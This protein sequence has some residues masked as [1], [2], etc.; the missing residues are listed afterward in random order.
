MREDEDA[1]SEG[2]GIPNANLNRRG[3][4]K[5]ATAGVFATGATANMTTV[6]ADAEYRFTAQ[7]T[8]GPV[9]PGE[10]F[11]IFPALTNIGD[12]SGEAAIYFQ[13]ATNASHN[14]DYYGTDFELVNHVDDGGQ[15]EYEGWSWALTE[16]EQALE[17]N[18][19]LEVDED[20]SSGEYTFALEATNTVQTEVIDTKTVTVTVEEPKRPEL[21]LTAK[22][23]S[24]PVSVGDSA[25]V[26]FE[27][28]NTGTEMAK[29]V[30]IQLQ[31]EGIAYD[32]EIDETASDPAG[33]AWNV[34]DRNW[35][36]DELPPNETEAP[37]VTFS[38]P[39]DVAPGTYTVTAEAKSDD[40]E[41]DRKTA[42]IV[43]KEP[44]RPE[45]EV[46]A[47]GPA[48]SVTAGQE[49]TVEVTLTNHGPGTASAVTTQLFALFSE[50]A[51][52]TIGDVSPSMGEWVQGL[53]W[54]IEDFAPEDGDQTL[55]VT[56]ELSPSIAAGEYTIEIET[57]L[58]S[59][60]VVPPQAPGSGDTIEDDAAA[61]I[62]VT[63]S[64]PADFALSTTTEAPQAT[65]GEPV[66]AAG[67]E[68]VI[69]IE[70]QN[71]GSTTGAPTV[72]FQSARDENDDTPA[73]QGFDLIDQRND[74]G[75]WTGQ[76]WEWSS[77][78]VDQTREPSVTLQ[79][80]ES[81]DPGPRTFDIFAADRNGTTDADS[82]DP[83]TVVST[84]FTPLRDGFPFYNWSG[85]QPSRGSKFTPGH[86]HDTIQEQIFVETLVS[87]SA[88][89]GDVATRV[90]DSVIRQWAR[91]L[92]DRYVQGTS[93]SGHCYG[94]AL[95]A[96]KYRQGGVPDSVPAES[97]TE[98][99]QPTGDFASVGDDIDEFQNSQMTD[100][101]VQLQGNV[102]TGLGSID[103]KA[104]SAAIQNK[105]DTAGVAMVGLGNTTTGALHQVLA[106]GYEV[107]PQGT[108]T[109]IYVYDPNKPNEIVSFVPPTYEAY[110]RMALI[111]KSVDITEILV[112][113]GASIGDMVY[114][115]IS[116]AVDGLVTVRA[117]S[118]VTIEAKTPDGTQLRH[119]RESVGSIPPA[120]FVYRT[121]VSAGEYDI[122]VSSKVNSTYK[123]TVQG[124]VPGAGEITD[125][126]QG[127]I[128]DEKTVAA[129]AT[130]P[131]TEGDKGKVAPPDPGESDGPAVVDYTGGNDIVRTPGLLDAI[132]D[133]RQNDIKSPLLLDVIEAWRSGQPVRKSE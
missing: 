68:F 76:G 123:L 33:G 92:Y 10:T 21:E 63:E 93:T 80:P 26:S 36:I 8:T 85:A 17:P 98:I 105:I 35:A 64:E 90:P 44:K 107:G 114:E 79:V 130:V 94:M 6:K 3:W 12:D 49:A 27:L 116:S 29:E 2:S 55:S 28:S 65:V 38:V 30:S 128:T 122:E 43:V 46:T 86:D 15:W 69:N 42:S 78:S 14:A 67:K 9:K 4:L 72:E 57:R 1:S 19:E 87:T 34:P 133:W 50:A 52:L 62:S 22:G 66:V 127:E 75:E 60:A 100:I 121:G 32:W 102:L 13:S 56:F 125:S 81:I 129:T 45:L 95:A 77:V 54:G 53:Q 131:A 48:D 18:V 58:E 7:S 103:V 84:D 25:T 73:F 117:S 74:G 115:A 71:T 24:D 118:P 119:P 132:S 101:N 106:Y 82:I 20:L 11:Q 110:D 120:Q 51:E 126:I 124:A 111:G 104:Q 31:A 39:D 37:A 70:V 83:L 99:S 96:K 112:E 5:L 40:A 109:A 113:E 108:P 61:T 47:T 89:P 97:T 88:L 91:K 23:P 16:P 41:T 59:P